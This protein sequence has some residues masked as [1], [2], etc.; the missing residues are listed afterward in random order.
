MD[1]EPGLGFDDYVQQLWRRS[2]EGRATRL[3]YLSAMCSAGALVLRNPHE[4][5]VVLL[6]EVAAIATL[7]AAIYPLWRWNK[8][9]EWA[10]AL[11]HERFES[12]AGE[13]AGELGEDRQI[14][15]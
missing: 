3:M 14:S 9:R 6:I 10:K 5:V 1:Q 7:F 2:R 8:R 4:G 13:R 11:S 15:M 12:L